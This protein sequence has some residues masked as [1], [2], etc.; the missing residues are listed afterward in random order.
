[1]PTLA[2]MQQRV[3]QANGPTYW[4]SLEELAQDETFLAQMR[5]EFPQF[6]TAQSFSTSR[7]GFLK[8]M[9]AMVAMTGLAGCGTQPPNE[10]IVPYVQQPEQILQGRPLFF[11]TALPFRGYARGA[12]VENHMGR[13]TKI[14]GNPQHPDSLG[15]TDPYMQGA[16]IDLYNPP[17]AQV[18]TQGGEINTW[19]AFTGALGERLAALQ[20]SQ[21]AGLAILTGTIT[22]RTAGAQIAALREALPNLRWHQYEPINRDNERAGLQLLF[23]QLLDPL[24]RFDQAQRILSLDADFLLK[25]PGSLRYARQ[26]IDARRGWARGDMSRLYAVESTP[27]L[28]GAKADHRLPLRASDIEG[29]ARG[30]AQALGVTVPGGDNPVAQTHAEWIN[31]VAADL[32]ANRGASLI[33]AGEE[34]PPAVHALAHALNQTLGNVGATVSYITPVDVE[35]VLQTESLQA[36]TEAMTAGEVN[37][38]LIVDCNPV[39]TAP[40]DLAFGEALAGVEF[41]VHSSLYFDETSARCQWHVP[42]AHPLES[43]SDLRADD[44]TTT[45]LQPLIAPLFEGKTIHELLSALA[46]EG[47]RSAYELVRGQWESTYGGL[48]NPPQPTFELF[49]D[50]SL[51]DGVVPGTAATP[52]QVTLAGD[53]ATQ[54]P[55]LPPPPEAGSLEL[56]FQPDPSIWDGRFAQNPWLQ[57]LPR[58]LTKLTWDNPAL[59]SPATAERLGLTNEALVQVGFQGQSLTVPVWITPGHPDDAVTLYLGYGRNGEPTAEEGGGFNTYAFRTTAAL[60]FGGGLTLQDT[61]ERYAL[62]S[63]QG[64]QVQENRGLVRASTFAHFQEDPHFAQGSQSGHGEGVGEDEITAPSLYPEYE[65]DGYAWGMAIDLTACIGCNAC[66]I[67]CQM[68][69][70]IPAVGKEGVL[71]G[72][73]MHW[74]LI[75]RYYEGE[76]Q[77]P[78]VYFEPR[79]CMH[80]EKAPCEPVCPVEATLHDSEG[81]NQMI[82]NRCVGTRYCSNNCPYKVRRFNYFD[83]H[84]DEIPLQQMWHNPDV[85]VRARGVMEKCTYCVQRINYAR[86]EAEKEDRRVVDGEVR[87]ACQQACPTRAIIFG[88]INDTESQVAQWKSQPLNYG[89]LAEIGTQPRTTY[90]AELKNPNPDLAA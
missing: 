75:D 82:Y 2:E 70:N 88:D 10:R 74:L 47:E 43:W 17:R 28:T 5:Q 25:L 65:Y 87:T 6:L 69:N 20:E 54:L 30:V 45:I 49:W 56:I 89:M 57:E 58:P 18:V 33:L 42:A 81:L 41:T 90:L 84:E 1:M 52:I 31:A 60:H 35:P 11:A 48:A 85:T 39:Y 3:A 64:H 46:G 12:L 24:Y 29:F 73:E 51:H 22:S 14:E 68:E 78:E 23:G 79:L 27:S 63:T 53:W 83:Y 9:G 16:I 7:R 61:G 59:I 50:M 62:A 71:R 19:G 34:Q 77:N 4:R 40:V 32:D 66:V 72:R 80:C 37:T 36:L 38:L 76:P 15:A 8:L 26:F 44:G 86:I 55:D 67:A 13:P 21:G